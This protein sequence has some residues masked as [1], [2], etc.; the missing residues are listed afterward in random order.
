MVE[1]GSAPSQMNAQ[2][3]A[4]TSSKSMPPAPTAMRCHLL[5]NAQ[6]AEASTNGEGSS[7]SSI[8][9]NS[10]T[11]PPKRLQITPWPNS[12]QALVMTNTT[13]SI[14]M[15]GLSGLMTPAKPLDSSSQCGSTLKSA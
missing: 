2:I 9:P 14:H 8:S 4:T 12:W 11:W 6:H 1:P 15:L 10:G 3:E 13:G 7:T 5:G